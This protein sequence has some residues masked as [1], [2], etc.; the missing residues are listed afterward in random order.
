MAEIKSNLLKFVPKAN[1]IE[2]KF[3]D[4]ILESAKYQKV[5]CVSAIDSVGKLD[6][7]S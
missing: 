5:V 7:T 4:V 2:K 6:C 1:D 3:L